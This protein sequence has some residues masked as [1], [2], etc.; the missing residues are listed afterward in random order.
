MSGRGV[1]LTGLRLH[2]GDLVLRAQ[3]GEI[4][5]ITRYGKP[6]AILGPADVPGGSRT[7]PLASGY[8]TIS[9]NARP[10]NLKG[11]ERD[12]VFALIDAVKAYEASMHKK[13]STLPP[14]SCP[15]T[16]SSAVST[17]PG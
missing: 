10:L 13:P 2:L 14:E 11:A 9:L 15:R 8:V 17:F 12:L 1:D 4:T 5:T 6:A 7:I 16:E 3:G